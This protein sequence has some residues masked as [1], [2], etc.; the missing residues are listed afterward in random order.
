MSG[1]DSQL[2]PPDLSNYQNSF[3]VTR[4]KACHHQDMFCAPALGPGSTCLG[5]NVGTSTKIY[6]IRPPS[7]SDIG[8]APPGPHQPGLPCGPALLTWESLG[9]G[10]RCADPSAGVWAQFYATEG[11]PPG[12]LPAEVHT[13][14]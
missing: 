6:H 10:A 8:L 3:S 11:Q 4:V 13:Q 12:L 5:L 14:V 2:T 7:P 1:L 9:K